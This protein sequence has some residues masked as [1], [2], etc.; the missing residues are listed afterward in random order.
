MTDAPSIND[1]IFDL[2]E[3]KEFKVRD[4]LVIRWCW[5]NLLA[6]PYFPQS[7]GMLVVWVPPPTRSMQNTPLWT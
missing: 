5:G 6:S 7:G 4:F 3:H 2:H 1:T